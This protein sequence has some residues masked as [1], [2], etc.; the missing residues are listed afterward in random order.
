MLDVIKEKV[1]KTL[2]L[3]GTGGN[4]LNRA[5]MVHA[6]RSRIDKWDVMKLGSFCKTKNIVNKK[7][8]KPADWEKNL[9]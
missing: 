7:N 9:H 8:Q 4:C 6:L 3:I 5:P 2:E 1:G